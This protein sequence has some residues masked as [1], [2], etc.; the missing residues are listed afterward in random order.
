MVANTNQGVLTPWET[1]KAVG[2]NSEGWL[3]QQSMVPSNGTH[4]VTALGVLMSYGCL[5]KARYRVTGTHPIKAVV[6]MNA[7]SAQVHG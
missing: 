3:S 4:P 6:A 2:G 7:T 5:N 1:A